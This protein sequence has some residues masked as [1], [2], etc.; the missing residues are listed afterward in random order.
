MAFSSIITVSAA[1]AGVPTVL[2]GCLDDTPV[3]LCH[4]IACEAADAI[5]T[6]ISS[7]NQRGHVLQILTARKVTWAASGMRIADVKFEAT[8]HCR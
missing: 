7:I 3:D 1:S 2:R 5:V 6:A 8:R 4:L